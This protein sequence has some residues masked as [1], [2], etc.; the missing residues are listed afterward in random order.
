[1]FNQQIP[2]L[3]EGLKDAIGFQ[4]VAG[5][6]HRRVNILVKAG[7][8]TLN[9]AEG[10]LFL[11]V[12]DIPAV[13]P[14]ECHPQFISHFPCSAG[15]DKRISVPV[16]A[17]PE[18]KL[19]DLII[20]KVR[21]VQLPFQ[22]SVQFSKGILVNV[23]HE[24][25]DVPGLVVGFRFLLVHERRQPQLLQGHVDL[26]DVIIPDGLAKPGNDVKHS[27]G[28]YGYYGYGYGYGDSTTKDGNGRK[29]GLK[30]LEGLSHISPGNP[31]REAATS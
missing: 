7:K 16:A 26:L 5:V 8:E 15:S 31:D 23:L 28:R 29:S 11:Q 4:G 25:E 2:G 12:A 3:K 19:H 20:R 30:E 22:V 14:H 24:I 10:E 21:C 13:T 18:T 1:M 9:P 27:R 17:R 6:D